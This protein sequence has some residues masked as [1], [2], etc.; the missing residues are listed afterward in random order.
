[1]APVLR[2]AS[3]SKTF[4]GLR[5]LDDVALEV[6]AGE[7]VSIVGQNGSGK[8]TLVKILAGLHQPD[9][10]A[11]IEAGELRF[12]HQDLGL[13]PSLSTM[14]NLALG[15]RERR[16]GALRPLRGRAEQRAAAAAVARFGGAFDVT[17]PVG[18]LSAAERAIVAI[19]RALD[20][21]EASSGVLVLDE[22]TAALPAREAARLFEAIR[23]VAAHG[24]GVLFISHRL[25]EVLDLSDRIV[26]LRDGRVV[27]DVPAGEVDHRRLVS[28]IVGRAVAEA[29]VN[30][31]V[32]AGAPVLSVRDL[33]GGALR[34]VTLDVRAGE[35]VGVAGLLGSGREDVAATIFG[36]DR[37]TG[38]EVMV[39]GARLAAGDPGAAIRAGVG[40]VPA[41]RTRHGAV[42]AHSVRENVTLPMLAP[43]RRAG[44]R[45]DER[46]ERAE[47]AGWAHA[48]GLHP[49]HPERALSEF[50]GGNQQ[51]VVLARWLRIRPR[52]LLLD[53]PTQGV[54]VGA[55]AAIYEIVARTASEG[56][57]VLV[58]SS[59]DK[60]LALLCD[61]VLVL[62]GGRIA[63]ELRGRA[64]TEERLVHE[65]LGVAGGSPTPVTSR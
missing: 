44:R 22:P 47:V 19:A 45:I 21:W 43:L 56:A 58:A 55:K 63:T 65:S 40:F 34:G 54:D 30:H 33:R 59:D 20:G 37:P 64:L 42:M 12:I 53:E 27:A 6:A 2:V 39:A 41:D 48:V 35:I 50:S 49:A 17:R 5:A 29:D 25:D 28:L 16:G 4:P 3:V 46:A 61:R 52:V 51:K 18:E 32:P 60:E 38:G 15:R 9:P 14:E 7:I 57:A 8:S 31:A 24:A 23:A 1:M 26:A 13:V 36:G 62:R 11:H 10:G